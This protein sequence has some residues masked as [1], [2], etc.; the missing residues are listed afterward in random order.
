MIENIGFD[1]SG[2]NCESTAVFGLS[3]QSSI[4]PFDNWSHIP[5]YLENEQT[6]KAYMDKH[7]LK[8][9]PGFSV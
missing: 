3:K 5:Y 6:V 4:I 1:G 8:T 9:Y 2:Q 7:G